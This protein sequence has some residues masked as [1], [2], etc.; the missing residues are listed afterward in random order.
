MLG[1]LLLAQGKWVSL[2]RDFATRLALGLWGDVRRGDFALDG[3]LVGVDLHVAE[4]E[5][6]GHAQDARVLQVRNVGRSDA[7][8][9]VDGRGA[10]RVPKDLDLAVEAAHEEGDLVRQRFPEGEHPIGRGLFKAQV[11]RGLLAFLLDE[12]D[13]DERV[14]AR[15]DVADRAVKRDRLVVAAFPAVQDR[16]A[17]IRTDSAGGIDAAVVTERID[18][19]SCVA[20]TG[21]DDHFVSERTHVGLQTRRDQTVERSVAGDVED[22]GGGLRVHVNSCKD[23]R[24]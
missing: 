11:Q 13:V 5:R 6:V 23:A 17:R 8:R 21:H 9:R 3:R 22:D 14:A 12:V 24:L 10:V 18:I 1:I 7:H 19:G 16:R 15:R 2:V 4:G 20:L